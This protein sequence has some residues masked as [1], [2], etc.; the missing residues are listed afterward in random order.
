VSVGLSKLRA[1]DIVVGRPTLW[2]IYDSKGLKLVSAG[3]VIQS[4]DQV[5]W[6]MD[7]GASNRP[8][9]VSGPLHTAKQRRRVEKPKEISPFNVLE[10]VIGRLA[11]TLACVKS[12]EVNFTEQVMELAKDIQRACDKDKSAAIATLFLVHESEYAIKHLVDV[13]VLVDITAKGRGINRESRLS[14]IAAALTMN[15]SI[16]DLQQ[17]VYLNTHSL[18]AEQQKRLKQHPQLSAQI[19]LGAK[20]VDKLWLKCVIAHHETVSGSGYPSGLTLE[21]YPKEA[22]LIALADYYCT[23]ISPR[24]ERNSVLHRD[25]MADITNEKDNLV[26]AELI[27][28]FILELGYYPPGTV[29][30]LANNEIAVVIKASANPNSPI[31]QAF[32]KPQIGNYGTPAKRN[33]AKDSSFKIQRVLQNDDPQITFNIKKVW[34]FPDDD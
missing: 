30:Q 24:T 31:V 5:Q 8:I 17:E 2:N 16:T 34:G 29:V 13:A 14:L 21:Q 25:V 9:E 4:K 12:K 32:M 27:Q 26:E 33:T 20:V 19:L 22:Q 28:F 23:K 1:D 10:R 15:I 6:L 11:L 7:R 3:T 18:T